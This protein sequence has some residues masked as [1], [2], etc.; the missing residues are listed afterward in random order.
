M[1][2]M[3]SASDPKNGQDRVEKAK[4]PQDA[5]PQRRAEAKKAFASAVLAFRETLPQLEKELRTSNSA[6]RATHEFR[7]SIALNPYAWLLASTGHDLEYALEC[8]ELA[9][10]LHPNNAAYIDTLARCHFKNGNITNAITLQK[11]AIAAEPSMREL[12]RNLQ[13]FEAALK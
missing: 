13:A 8:S 7:Y 10:R 9:C 4:V 12:Q 1:M 3:T 5:Q 11:Q 6:V 2:D